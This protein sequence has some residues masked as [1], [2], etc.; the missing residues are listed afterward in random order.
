MN[1][2]VKHL[3][4]VTQCYC[5]DPKK[6]IAPTSKVFPRIRTHPHMFTLFGLENLSLVTVTEQTEGSP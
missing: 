6:E 1:V 2:H 3:N 5:G 4:T